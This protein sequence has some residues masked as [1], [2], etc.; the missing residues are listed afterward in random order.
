[1]QAVALAHAGRV[2]E[3]RSAYAELRKRVPGL[4]LQAIRAMA[5]AMASDPAHAA[6]IVAAFHVAAGQ[7]V[8]AA[9]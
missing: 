9:E 5:E 8:P 6:A 4:D 2:Q 7:D 1:V 3:S